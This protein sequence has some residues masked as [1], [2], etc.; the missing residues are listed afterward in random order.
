M[1]S[2]P[3]MVTEEETLKL[4]FS[5]T[6]H[7]IPYNSKK[8]FKQLLSNHLFQIGKKADQLSSS[9]FSHL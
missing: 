6:Q 4:T 8:F 9:W 1:Y 7:Y 5:K 2:L 3:Q